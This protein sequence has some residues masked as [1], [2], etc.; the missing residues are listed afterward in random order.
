MD[1]F[2]GLNT[3]EHTKVKWNTDKS[4]NY[5]SHSKT[6]ESRHSPLVLSNALLTLSRTIHPFPNETGDISFSIPGK[7]SERTEGTSKFT[8][9]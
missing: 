3:I 7:S 4:D 6:T 9:K 1:F 2:C 8:M 5:D